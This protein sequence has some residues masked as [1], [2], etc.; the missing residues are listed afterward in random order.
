MGKPPLFRAAE[1]RAGERRRFSQRLLS[2]TLSSLILR[3][4]RGWNLGVLGVSVAN[5][6]F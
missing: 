3:E 5:T 1:E 2:L 6:L 4:E